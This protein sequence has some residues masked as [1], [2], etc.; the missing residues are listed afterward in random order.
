M[1]F[2]SVPIALRTTMTATATS[3]RIR[4]YSTRPWPS[5][6]RRS[7]LLTVRYSSVSLVIECV[8]FFLVA[9]FCDFAG[10]RDWDCREQCVESFVR[11]QQGCAESS[12][13]A[14]SGDGNE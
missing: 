2:R 4:P 5:S 14:N 7:A 10:L 9:C 3:A 12:Q 1:V 8:S 6:S 11:L 13:G